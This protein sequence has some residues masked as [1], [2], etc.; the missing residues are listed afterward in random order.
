[1]VQKAMKEAVR[2][3]GISKP[4]TCHSLRNVST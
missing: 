3:S 2:R 4:A 1:V